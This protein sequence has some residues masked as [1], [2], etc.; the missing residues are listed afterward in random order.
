MEPF[1]IDFFK[2]VICIYI[3]SVSFHGLIA[4]FVLVLSNV[5][6]PG[7]ATVYVSIHRLKDTLVASKFRQS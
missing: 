4:P 7:R 1:Q 2:S 5:P 3:S 6:L